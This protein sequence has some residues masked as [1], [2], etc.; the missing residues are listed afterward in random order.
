MLARH[1]AL[2][3]SVQ[4]SS[5]GIQALDVSPEGRTVATI[6]EHHLVTLV[7]RASG[8]QR[9]YQAGPAKAESIQLRTL[10]FS[11]DGR[12]L[13]VGRTSDSRHPVL[14]LDGGTL[15][16]LRHQ[17]GGLPPGRWQVADV[18]WSQD[19]RSVAAG[20]WRLKTVKGD[21]APGDAVAAVWRLD[22]P[23]TPAFID[24]AGPPHI[25]SDCGYLAIALS[26]H[27][28]RLYVVPDAL[29][30]NVRIGAA[31]RFTD[32]KIGKALGGIAVS[33]DGRLVV[34]SRD[35][36]QPG[37]RGAVLVDA[38]S[39]RTVR[40][41]AGSQHADDFRFSRSGNRLLTIDWGGDGARHPQ[42]WD[43]SSGRLLASA[44][45]DGGSHRAVDVTPDGRTVVSAD[46][47]GALRSWDPF[48]TGGYLK[49][50]AFHGVMPDVCMATPSPDARFVAFTICSADDPSLKWAEVFLDV[51]KR[52]SHLVRH[53]ND[54]SWVGN[55]GWDGPRYLHSNEG[56]IRVFYARDGTQ[57]PPVHPLATG[58]STS[59]TRQ[60]AS[61]SSRSR[62]TAG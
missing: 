18:S 41:L 45:I 38:D 61:M 17:L 4:L 24:V 60:T 5:D 10:R 13:A 53:A 35:Q 11:P 34:V 40:H 23:G 1:P 31:H 30:Y 15:T 47:D 6:D 14:L 46:L 22:R 25:A 12:T 56:D 58:S 50:I 28:D 48:G 43:V 51:A 19:G 7:D 39:G 55:G 32:V 33:P 16:P 36:G 42:I 26:P 44:S 2:L 20:L 49:R 37:G 62:S 59:S 54:G 29:A 8:A 52:S 21:R 27:G 9:T 57:L 3:G